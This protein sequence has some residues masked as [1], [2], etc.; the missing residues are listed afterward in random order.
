MITETAYMTI[1][2]GHAEAFEAAL[3]QARVLVEQTPG[4]RGLTIHRGVERP[5]VYLILIEWDTLDD[6]LVSFRESER[7]GQ[8]RA[9]LGPHYA[10]PPAVEHWESRADAT[11]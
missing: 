7:F 11:R 1:A 9:L 6:H 3:A 2:D 10:A 8:W 5:D 4:C